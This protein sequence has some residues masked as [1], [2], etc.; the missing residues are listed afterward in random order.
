[1]QPKD[2]PRE[3][4]HPSHLPSSHY[5]SLTSAPVERSRT[6]TFFG[7][8]RQRSSRRCARRPF[9]RPERCLGSRVLRRVSLTLFPRAALAFRER[10]LKMSNLAQR[11]SLETDAGEPFIVDDRG[12]WGARDDL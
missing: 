11:R 3:R 7:I 4:Q 8:H 1:M 12:G 5:G 2:A 9:L 10:T 6:H